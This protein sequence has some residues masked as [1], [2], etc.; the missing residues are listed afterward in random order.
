MSFDFAYTFPNENYETVPGEFVTPEDYP[1][2]H[3]TLL[4]ATISDT[5]A[6]IAL[7]VPAKGQFEAC[8]R[9]IGSI[10]PPQQQ[11]GRPDPASRWREKLFTDLEGHPTNKSTT[12]SQD[13]SH[14]AAERAIQSVRRMGN[15]IR[16]F[17]QERCCH[18]IGGDTDIYPFR[19]EHG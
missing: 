1:S 5:R 2:Q 7:P 14:G 13:R 19:Q 4:V 17:C 15:C 9:R 11:P 12:R 8:G 10:Q 6:V 3:G 16:E 18:H